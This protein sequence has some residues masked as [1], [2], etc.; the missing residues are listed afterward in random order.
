MTIPE[1]CVLCGF[2]LQGRG[3]EMTEGWMCQDASGCRRRTLV[4][5]QKVTRELER[6]QAPTE[7]CQVLAWPDGL[8]C[9]LVEGHAGFHTNAGT[10]WSHDARPEEG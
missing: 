8:Q 9:M 1:S 6:L 3:Q 10:S 5:L 7:R 4:K 2:S